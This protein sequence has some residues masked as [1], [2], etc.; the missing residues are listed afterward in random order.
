M[1]LDGE[2]VALDGGRP[3]FG[4]LAERMHVRDRRKAERLAATR[5]VTLMVFDLL[6]LFGSDLTAQ[7]LSAR[8]ELLERL[9]LDGRHWQVPPV[10]DDGPELLRR[11]PGAG[12]RGRRQQAARPRPTC[13]GAARPTGSSRHTAPRLSAVVGGWRPEKTNDSGRLGAVLLGAPR[14]RR[15]LAVSP[16]GWAAASPDAGA[17][18]A[19][20]ARSRPLTRPDSPFSDEVPRHRRRRRDLGRAPS[21]VMEARTLEVTRDGTAAPAGIPRRAHRPDA[22]RTCRRSTMPEVRARGDPRRGGRAQAQADQPRQA[23]VPLDR[24]DQGRGARTTT[25]RSPTC[26]CPTSADRPVTR[27]R[28]PHGVGDQS[29][30]EKNLPSGAPVVAAARPGRRRHLPAGRGPRRS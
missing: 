5:P 14:R 17:A 6:R 30:F 28:W 10:Y 18:P 1:L 11:H 20:R 9:D 26:C 2:V 22:R 21:V 8:R 25:R 23:A 29:F 24:D 13:P 16:G 7:P 19:R 4:A 12:P 15:R 3:S 27:V